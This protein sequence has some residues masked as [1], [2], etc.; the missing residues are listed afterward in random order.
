[1]LLAAGAVVCTLNVGTQFLLAQRYERR[2]VKA[3]VRALWAVGWPLVVIGVAY[4]LNQRA[5]D[6]K[7][8]ATSRYV[9]VAD[10]SSVLLREA[11]PHGVPCE[12][13]AQPAF[14]CEGHYWVNDTQPDWVWLCLAPDQDALGGSGRCATRDES[15]LLLMTGHGPKR[16]LDCHLPKPEQPAAP[17][18]S[19]P[20]P[21]HTFPEPP[22][23][24]LAPPSPPPSPPAPPSPPPSPPLLP[25]FE[26]ASER[27]AWSRSRARR[28]ELRKLYDLEHGTWHYLTAVGCSMMVLTA[29]EG[30]SGRASPPP[31]R[32]EWSLTA[33][34]L[35]L[36]LV[37]AL[38][39]SLEAESDRWLLAWA[40]LSFVATAAA[41][42]ILLRLVAALREQQR[43][44][45]A[46]CAASAMVGSRPPT[47]LS[48]RRATGA[49]PP[50]P[51]AAGAAAATQS[52]AC[53]SAPATWHRRS[54]SETTA[55][56]KP[57]RLD[58]S[59]LLFAHPPS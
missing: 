31:L 25:S 43:R 54:R 30:L 10:C 49:A 57:P 1:M 17:P 58:G 51:P 37:F 11:T 39:S 29:L 14:S 45:A 26:E 59:E 6:N 20:S 18:P 15:R 38:M 9:W 32:E 21:R 24:P 13:L 33:L 5:A 4:A 36:A 27:E 34:N 40:L 19:A 8:L 52:P 16:R 23:P 41:A 42:A 44:R 53:A 28:V 7:G 3:A 50:E 46:W 2:R 12:Q 35:A 56:K 47:P 48:T 22:L 55:L